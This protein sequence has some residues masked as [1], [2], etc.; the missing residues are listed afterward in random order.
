MEI[1]IETAGRFIVDGGIAVIF[2]GSRENPRPLSTYRI[3][4]ACYDRLCAGL[5]R[6]ARRDLNDRLCAAI[7]DAIDRHHSA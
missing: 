4:N 6:D 1:H 5:D 7:N 2:D 3:F